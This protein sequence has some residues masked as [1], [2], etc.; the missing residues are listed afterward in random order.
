MPANGWKEASSGWVETA[1]A[2][3]LRYEKPDKL[4]TVTITRNPIDG[5]SVVLITIQAR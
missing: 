1:Q 2:T 4:S 3:V 5:R